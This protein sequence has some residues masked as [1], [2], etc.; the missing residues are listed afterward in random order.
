MEQTVSN[1]WKKEF[2]HTVSVLAGGFILMQLASYFVSLAVAQVTHAARIWLSMDAWTFINDICLYGLGLP[3][4]MLMSQDLPSGAKMPLRPQKAMRPKQF[5]KVLCISYAVVVLA[6]IV[7]TMLTSFLHG[8]N[9]LVSG[10]MEEI[11]PFG[12][13]VLMSL[14]PAIG[15]ELVFRGYLYKKLIRFGEKP[16]IV[17]SALFFATFHGNLEQA[18]YAFA[19]GLWLAYLVCRTGSVVYGVMIHL[20]INFL[21]G[22][23]LSQIGNTTAGGLISYLM[24]AMV[25]AG[26]VFLFRLRKKLVVRPAQRPVPDAVSLA[27]GNLGMV[28][29]LILFLLLAVTSLWM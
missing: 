11:S 12:G 19:L 13:F 26:C 28:L 8:S 17:L 20:F 18:G 10:M 21:S 29:W 6:N 16:Y 3:L 14:V 5:F 9:D 2:R 24:F 7:T 4:L 23:V 25:A 22:A 15:E 1:L 27:V